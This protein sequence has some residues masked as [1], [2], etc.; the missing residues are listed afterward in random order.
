MTPGLPDPHQPSEHWPLAWWL[1][2]YAGGWFPMAEAD[3][4]KPLGLF[5]SRRRALMPLDQRFTI[6][7]SVRRA[8]RTTQRDC[9]FTPSLNRA[10]E[11]VVAGCS[12]RPSTWISP[13]L[14]RI[15]AQLHAAG[16]AH[17]VELWEGDELAAG[18]LAIGVGACWIGES[19]AH[20]RPEAGNL[21]L[22]Q[23]VQALRQGG[24]ALFDIQLSNPHLERFGCFQLPDDAYEIA[25]H[26]A[27]QRPAHLR[28]GEDA[29][30][31]E[32]WMR[33]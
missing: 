18:L 13:E 14:V 25:L 12:D 6:P 20:W 4:A 22:V 1:Q 3:P 24:F 23:L 33:E 15:Y 28:L 27:R 8:L 5:R 26:Q 11:Q 30:T 19:M 9:R 7:R 29:I 16:V 21:L 31:S 17:S 10:F 32:A 2:A